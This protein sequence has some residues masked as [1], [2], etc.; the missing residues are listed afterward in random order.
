[1]DRHHDGQRLLVD[2]FDIVSGRFDTKQVHA[3]PIQFGIRDTKLSAMPF[4]H[5][6]SLRPTERSLPGGPQCSTAIGPFEGAELYHFQARTI[7][8]LDRY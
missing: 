4:G 5:A 2:Q 8:R 3:A 1:M 7:D 6:K